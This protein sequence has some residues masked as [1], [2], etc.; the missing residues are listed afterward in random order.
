M[1]DIIHSLPA[2]AA[3]RRALPAARTERARVRVGAGV[4]HAQRTSARD[5][6][7]PA[8]GAAAEAAVFSAA[9]FPLPQTSAHDSF[10]R[11]LALGGR[12]ALINP[13][14]GWGAKC[15]P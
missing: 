14:A 2:V 7:Q 3:L 6:N 10:L 11:E 12:F 8:T 4:L 15:W 1:G 9:D 5:E 13:G